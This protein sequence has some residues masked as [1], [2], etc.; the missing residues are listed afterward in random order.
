MIC[1]SDGDGALATVPL[2]VRLKGFSSLS[3]FVMA[4][5]PPNVPSLADS[6]R[7]VND[8]D[9]PGANPCRLDRVTYRALRP[10]VRLGP[11][12]PPFEKRP[13]E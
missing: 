10:G 11:G 2:S 4:I 1:I 12:G 3:S 9:S 6:R 5:E 7:T 13:A 8:V